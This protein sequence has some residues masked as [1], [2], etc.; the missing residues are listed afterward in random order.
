[1]R[2]TLSKKEI[3]AFLE[4][5]PEAAVVF[6]KKS[7]VVR[8]DDRLL[9]DDKPVFFFRAGRWLPSFELL[10]EHKFFPLVVVDS[11]TPPFLAKGADLMRPGVVSCEPFSKGSLVT[12]VDEVHRF[13]L[14]VG[15]ALFS[16]D[17]LMNQEKGKVV[18]VLLRL[19][20][21]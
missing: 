2:K 19:T 12:I 9:L 17:D 16:S 13:P 5:H 6:S 14:A 8:D 1:M 3:K 18:S 4:D 20:D 15:E 11:G 7:F 10:R 21:Y